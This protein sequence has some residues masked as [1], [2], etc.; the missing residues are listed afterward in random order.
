VLG[1]VACTAAPNESASNS[2]EITDVSPTSAKEQSVPNCWLYAMASWAEAMHD[3]VAG[4][5]LDLSE[6]YWTYWHWFDQLTTRELAYEPVSQPLYFDPTGNWA[7]AAEI[8]AR[9]G[10]MLEGDFLPERD[11]AI[12]S[13]RQWLAIQLVAV[14]IQPGGELDTPAKRTPAAIRP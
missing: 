9:R 3:G 8:V 13:Q 12:R 6:S 4:E 11:G 10:W 5:A 14:A 1:A 7:V 2:S